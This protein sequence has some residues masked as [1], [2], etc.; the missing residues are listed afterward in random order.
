MYFTG[1]ADEAAHAL[2]DQIAVT[3]ELGWT[4]IE[5][6]KID[7][8]MIHDLS[9]EAFDR[10]CGQLAGS[11]VAINCFGSAIANWGTQIDQ[12]FAT[13]LD[14]TK[15][16]IPRMQRLGTKLVRIMS[17]AVRKGADGRALDDQMEDERFRRLREL[18][19]MFTG[20]GLL[21]VHENCMNFGGMGWTYTRK[22]LDHVPG[23]KLVFDTGNPTHSDDFSVLARADGSRPKQSSWEF[24]RNI[25]EQ[26]AYVH[27]KDGKV[28]ADGKH[29]HTW[30]GEGDGDVRRVLVDLF[31][32]G[33]DGGISIEP[34]IATVFHDPAVTGTEAKMRASYLEYG[35]RTIRLVGE[36]K[37][38]VSAARG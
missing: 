23:L 15:R 32:R 8:T 3:K 18:H 11:G 19:A 33:Y 38:Q 4:N 6:R 31:S 20:A 17:F 27:I 37:A 24:Y 35:R 2:A 13:T 21:P 12:P 16:A 22:M 5:S 1:F 28:G 29:V 9:D 34:H 36:A 10:V 30:P 25:R 7:G 26:I 14:Q